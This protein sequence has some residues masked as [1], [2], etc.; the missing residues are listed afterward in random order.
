MSNGGR[1]NIPV[2]WGDDIGIS[3]PSCDSDGVKAT[4]FTVD[5]IM[6]TRLAGIASR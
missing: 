3:K 5:Q 6:V 2:I 4:S 1:A